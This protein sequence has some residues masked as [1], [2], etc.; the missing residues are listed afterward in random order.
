MQENFLNLTKILW[1][2]FGWFII[3]LGVVELLFWHMWYGY[4]I[5]GMGIIVL[6]VSFMFHKKIG[7]FKPKILTPLEEIRKAKLEGRKYW[8]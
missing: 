1:N 4:F 8:Y 5:I 7:L 2:K 6:I 3:I